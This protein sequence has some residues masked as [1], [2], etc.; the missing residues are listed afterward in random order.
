MKIPKSSLRELELA[1]SSI[2]ATLTERGPRVEFGMVCAGRASEVEVE[3]ERKNCDRRRRLPGLALS[4][5]PRLLQSGD[6]LLC[7][8]RSSAMQ[9]V[10]SQ[11]SRRHFSCDV[12]VARHPSIL[13]DFPTRRSIV[14]WLNSVVARS[15][16]WIAV[17]PA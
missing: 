2:S 13:L 1:I 6:S 9:R 17:A 10:T 11:K 8:A 12:C 16:R 15:P 14:S 3:A 7:S 5:I 4:H